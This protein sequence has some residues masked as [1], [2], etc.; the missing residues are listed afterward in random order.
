MNTI[1]AILLTAQA[2]PPAIYRC[3]GNFYGADLSRSS[4]GV[5]LLRLNKSFAADG[6]PIDLDVSVTADDGVAIAPEGRSTIVG[7]DW[8]DA[9]EAA[10]RPAQFDWSRGRIVVS[11]S[12]SDGAATLRPGEAWRRVIVERDDQMLLNNSRPEPVAEGDD[13]VVLATDHHL[14]SELLA[15]DMRPQLRMSAEALLAWGSGRQRLIV[16]ETALT[17]SGRDGRE[18]Y[19]PFGRERLTGRYEIDVPALARLVARVRQMTEEWEATLT[20]PPRQCRPG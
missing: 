1:L 15:P 17:P 18:G 3:E 19:S 10:P 4:D 13:V 14:A 7:L 8:S 12:S 20:D 9:G 16:Y 5:G 2:Q 6:A 11:Y